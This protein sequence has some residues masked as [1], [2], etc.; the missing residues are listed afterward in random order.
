ME[1]VSRTPIYSLRDGRRIQGLVNRGTFDEAVAPLSGDKD[2]VA[3]HKSYWVNLRHIRSVSSTRV[4]LEN[5]KELPVSRKHAAEVNRRYLKYLADGGD[6][7][8]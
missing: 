5:G 2:F 3:I 1:N 6:N 7:E 8:T 4:V